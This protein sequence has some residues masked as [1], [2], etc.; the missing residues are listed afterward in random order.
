[1]A[2]HPELRPHELR[3]RLDEAEA[4]RD[5]VLNAALDA[6]ITAD[7]DCRVT[8]WNAAAERIF[9]WRVEEIMGRPIGDTIV[10]GHHR[11]AHEAGL[12]RYHATGCPHV[13]GQRLELEAMR[14]DGS[15]FPC[16]LSIHEVKAAG[17]SFFTAWLR[18]LT[19]LRQAQAEVARQRERLHQSEKMSALGSLLAGVAH[20]LNNPL[21]VVVAQTTML[22][23]TAPDDAV[24]RRA[25][26]G[27]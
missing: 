7:R 5:G 20:E 21:A 9:G 22:E 17:R 16:E 23:A 11:A 19:P 27:S 2:R 12:A 10:P 3:G 18:D 15:V 26:G 14:A 24:R 6:V 25:A 13:L 1:M 4:L 8:G